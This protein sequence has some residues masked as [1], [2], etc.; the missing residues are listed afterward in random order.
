M[1]V[2]FLI[3]F[4]TLRKRLQTGNAQQNLAAKC[5]GAEGQQKSIKPSEIRHLSKSCQK[6]INTEV[7]ETKKDFIAAL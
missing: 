5:K 4:K 6:M 7:I 2:L 3:L 1:N